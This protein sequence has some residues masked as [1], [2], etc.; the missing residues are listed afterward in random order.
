MRLIKTLVIFLVFLVVS[1]NS[2]AQFLWQISHTSYDGQYGYGFGALS[3]SGNNCTAAGLLADKA[4]KKFSILFWRS[5]DGAKTWSAQDP[6]FSVS[7]GQNKVVFQVQQIDSLNVAA[8]GVDHT[9][10]LDTGGHYVLVDTGFILH[11][12][13]AGA[14]WKQQQFP[15]TLKLTY[16]HFSDPLNGI[17]TT[18]TDGIA[19]SVFTTADGGESWKPVLNF[20]ASDLIQCHCFGPGKYSVLGNFW[21]P[22]YM[23]NDNWSTVDVIDNF[24]DKK[25]DSLWDRHNI[26]GCNFA[27]EDTI[28]AYGSYIINSYIVRSTDRGKHWEEPYIGSL[29]GAYLSAMTPLDRDTVFAAGWS[30]ERIYFSSNKGKTWRDDPILLDTTYTSTPSCTWLDWAGS[31]PIAVFQQS[32]LITT[33]EEAIIV[34]GRPSNSSVDFDG[35]VRYNERVFPNPVTNILNIASVE[36]GSQFRIVDMMGRVAMKGMTLDRA[37]LSV[38]VS[39][40]AAGAYFVT[41]D[42]IRDGHPAVVGKIL[43]LGK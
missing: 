40:L 16:M 19:L 41:V 13:D 26:R 30:S 5:N 12:T 42:D 24:F 10:V 31:R 17:I 32:F 29:V 3:C 2:Q 8:I 11:T 14:T 21:G 15:A 18:K 7:T 9:F 28:I 35:P 25:T 38:D 34:V 4:N 39:A 22:L 6:K 43:L 36:A 23:T 27:G 37:T 33:G 1:S 20:S